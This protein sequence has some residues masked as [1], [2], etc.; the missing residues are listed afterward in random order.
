MA[1][2]KAKEI[3]V[4]GPGRMG[5]GIALTFALNRFQV[6]LFDGKERTDEG[7]GAIEKKAKEELRSNIW[8]LKRIGR[9]EGSLKEILSRIVFSHD[10]TAEH[11]HV[12]FVFEAIPEKPDWKVELFRQVSPLLGKDT[13]LAS[14]TSTIDLKTMSRG[15]EAPQRFMITH[16][17]NPAFII[18]LV[19]VAVSDRTDSVSVDRMK[20][21]LTRIGKVPVVLKDSP[22]FII[23]R[24]QALAMN[25]AIRILEEGVATAKD[26]DTAIK[27]GFAFRLGVVGLLEFVDLGG[28]DILYYADEFLSSAFKN[29]RFNQP[30]LVE[31]KMKR[32]EI[33]PRTGKGIF[34]YKDVD[35]RA[36]FEKKYKDLIKLLR[37]MKK[38]KIL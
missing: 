16:W 34:D 17:L 2:T 35:V 18:P 27:T 19:E 26:I 33:G 36:V 10:L 11:F 3:T 9:L 38:N 30:R 22:G 28:L 7:Y 24:I 37:F 32:G 25:E 8:L 6:T 4:I 20:K 1:T 21:V 12:P 29:E 15:V 5:L 23:P 13:I 31:D 14:T